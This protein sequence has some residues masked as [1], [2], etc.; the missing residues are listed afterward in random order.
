MKAALH[1]A[2]YEM[3]PDEGAF[4]GEMPDY[5]GVYA[6]TD[7][8]EACREQLEEVLEEMDFISAK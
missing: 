8:L 7:T 4:Y 1:N 2:K 3:L 5:K 6:N